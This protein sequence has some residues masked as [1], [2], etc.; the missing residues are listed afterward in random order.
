MKQILKTSLIIASLLISLFLNPVSTFAQDGNLDSAD[1]YQEQTI[2]S[3]DGTTYIIMGI[4]G[5]P[6]APGNFTQD[7][8]TTPSEGDVMLSN[9]PDY[10]WNYGCTPTAA[11]MIAGWY[12]NNGFEN[13][14]TGPTNGGNAPIDDSLW[15]RWTD[16][17]RNYPANP[18]SASK[19]GHDGRDTHG[20]I[21]SYWIEHYSI[22]PDPFI[23]N[24]W[25]EHEYGQAIGDYMK[26]GQS[27]LRQRDGYS[28]IMFGWP[29]GSNGVVTCEEVYEHESWRKIDAMLGLKH[30][31]EAQGYQIG[32]CYNAFI[33]TVSY[34]NEK[35]F[36]TF[37]K[38]MDE[39]DNGHPVLVSLV[40]HSV[41]AYGYNEAEQKIIIR[42]TWTSSPQ[43]IIKMDWGGTLTGEM[44]MRAVTI[45]HPVKPNGDESAP[46]AEYNNYNYF[47]LIIKN[48]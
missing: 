24:E 3:D 23:D 21:D 31:Y 17:H 27:N 7:V 2:T 41:V 35:G 18:L 29:D 22:D 11:A 8:Q 48:D 25:E 14:Y 39:I 32:D 10:A 9:F 46:P 43:K 47:P 16:G 37:E 44:E 36:F 34:Q 40:G 5:P 13:L 42:T 45:L 38:F 20:S 28:S 6:K 15:T 19:M 30:Y 12:D 1:F 33:D 26:T 4:N